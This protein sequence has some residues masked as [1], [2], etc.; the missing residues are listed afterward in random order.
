VG[1]I[2]KATHSVVEVISTLGATIAEMRTIA[3]AVARTMDDQSSVTGV[4][5]SSTQEAAVSASDITANVAL[6]TASMEVSGGAAQTV[7]R[8]AAR[9]TEEVET[10]GTELVRFLDEVRAA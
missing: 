7:V 10:L 4:I 9:M 1:A 5:A 3:Q 8:A 6:V 2:Q